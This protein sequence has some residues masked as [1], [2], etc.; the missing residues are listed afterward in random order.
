[1]ATAL[2]INRRS[3]ALEAVATKDDTLTLSFSSESPVARSFGDEVLS[4]A[5][6]AVDLSRLN[7]GAPLLWNHDPNQLLGVVESAQI[8]SSKGRA[9]VRWGASPEAQQR[10]ADVENGVIRNVSVGYQIDELQRQGEVYV[11]TSWTPLEI[12]LVSIAADPNVGIGRSLSQPATPSMTYAKQQPIAGSGDLDFTP[13]DHK[14]YSLIRAVKA[15][16]TGDWSQ[17]GFERECSRALEQQMGREARGFFMPENL[18]VRTPY[19]TSTA[20]AAGNLV[21]TELHGEMFIDALRNRLAVAELGATML[22]G[23]VGNVDIPRRTGLTSTYWVAEGSAVTESNGTFDLVSLRPKTVGALSSWT[24]LMSL[25]STPQLEDLIR[26]D[27]VTQLATAIDLAAINGSG[28]SNQ[29]TGLL[30]TSGVN[31]VAGGTNGASITFD[32]LADLKKEVAIDNADSAS[33]GYLSNAKVEAKL[34]KL[35]TSG[36]GEY[37]YGP[38]AGTPGSVWGRRFVISNQ[39]PSNLTKG[40]ASGTCSAVIYGNWSDLL[41]GM[42]GA[43]DVLVNP[44]GSGFSAGNL[45]LRAMQTI[46]I[47]VRHPESFAVMKDA[48]VA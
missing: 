7:D 4:H 26:Q 25:Q 20:N 34:M 38:G 48:L 36:S 37:F 8:S 21:G 41:V 13:A 29:P 18:S 14:R 43:T 16:A 19:I 40:S 47:A 9:V 5:A 3:M 31:A 6:G 15:A 22:P 17:A 35:T 27:M 33:A 23:L 28:S 2:E 24:R 10:R 1:M 45:E 42:W 32:H 39:I 46:D 30:N 12:S 44:F 11:A